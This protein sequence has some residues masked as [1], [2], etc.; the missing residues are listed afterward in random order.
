MR[1]VETEAA[2]D[3]LISIIF[4]SMRKLT[5]ELKQ[6]ERTLLRMP[7]GAYHNARKSLLRFATTATDEDE[8]R[9]AILAVRETNIKR[10]P[11]AFL[12]A[13]LN[14][15]AAIQVLGIRTSA[16]MVRDD[17]VSF[18]ESEIIGIIRAIDYHIHNSVDRL[19]KPTA[20]ELRKL[21]ELARE[22]LKA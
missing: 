9:L 21:K 17:R 1:K 22:R 8:R 12:L 20:Q 7:I 13:L 11:V 18:T 4:W 6:D 5:S 3:A 15:P 2:Q 19:E 10:F 16:E 14:Q